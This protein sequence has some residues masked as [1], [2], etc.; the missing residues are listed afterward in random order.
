MEERD[1]ALRIAEKSIE[2]MKKALTMSVKTE[3]QVKKE[4]ELVKER[5]AVADNKAAGL[6]ILVKEAEE[7]VAKEVN[8]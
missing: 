6:E 1:K 4:L 7:R 5:A 2:D 8:Q 3:S